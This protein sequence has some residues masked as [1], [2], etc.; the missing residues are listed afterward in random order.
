MSNQPLVIGLVNNMPAAAR[1]ATERQFTR[2]LGA[3]VT[4][5]EVRLQCYGA[6]PSDVVM[7][8]EL[9]DGYR[10]SDEGAAV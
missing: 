6:V 8:A 7:L 5:R 9:L 4:D 10:H 1:A 2:L 3:A